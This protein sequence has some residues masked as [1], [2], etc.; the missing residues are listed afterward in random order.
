MKIDWD[1]HVHQGWRRVLGVFCIIFALASAGFYYHGP[2]ATPNP[3]SS[4]SVIVAIESNDGTTDPTPAASETPI[5]TES[6]VGGKIHIQTASQAELETLPQ[7]GPAKALAII[8]YRERNGFRSIEDLDKVKGIGPATLE[9]LRPL[10]E[11]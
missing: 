4:P 9:K 11:L 2:K 6:P 3:T 10:I 7:I 5:P 1:Q 8:D